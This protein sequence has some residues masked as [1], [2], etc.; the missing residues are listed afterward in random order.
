MLLYNKIS[1]KRTLEIVIIVFVLII[2]DWFCNFICMA[3]LLTLL[4]I[5]FLFQP[6]KKIL[7]FQ[8]LKLFSVISVCIKALKVSKDKILPLSKILSYHQRRNKVG[9]KR[10]I[11]TASLYFSLIWLC[12]KFLYFLYS[13]SKIII[14]CI[15][16][17]EY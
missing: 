17:I 14:Y 10:I 8:I 11:Y 5:S 1:S 12:K 16:L 7:L 2:L 3:K 13:Y 4:K 6:R 15:L 9:G